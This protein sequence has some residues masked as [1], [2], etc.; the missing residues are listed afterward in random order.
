MRHV[1]ETFPGVRALNDVELTVY[2]GEVHALMGENGAGNSTL[3]KILSGGVHRRRGCG[4]PHWRQIR[5][6]RGTT[7]RQGT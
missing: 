1:S 5:G 3:M 4:D 2:P 7:W 6:D